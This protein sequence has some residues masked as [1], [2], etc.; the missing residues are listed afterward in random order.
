MNSLVSVV[1]PVYNTDQFY[2]K[3]CI[4]SLREQTLKNIEIILV[5]DGSVC[6][7]A[8]VCDK[9]AEYDSRIISLHQ[10]NNGVSAARNLGIQKASGKYITFV[11][12]DDW[13]DRSVLQDV[14]DVA[15]KENAD[16]TL[17]GGTINRIGRN[18]VETACEIHLEPEDLRNKDYLYSACCFPKNHKDDFV[19]ATCSKLYKREFLLKNEISFSLGVVFGED[20]IFA[21]KAFSC[22]SSVAY[23]DNCGYHYR[24]NNQNQATSR[25]LPKLTE[26]MERFVSLMDLSI[27][28][29]CLNEKY[30]TLLNTSLI[31]ILFETILP[32]VFFHPNNPLKSKEKFSSFV[33]YMRS[34]FVK[35]LVD[36]RINATYLKWSHRIALLFCQK[37]FYSPFLL[38]E[39][40]W[41]LQR[42]L[43]CWK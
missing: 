1:V 13:C 35:S 34:P 9:Y 43:D 18:G 21:V 2:L 33:S 27:R 16:V 36:A 11:D 22:C 37:D 12:S 23:S 32:Q 42:S 39:K 28:E 7:C 24:I 14:Y 26:S 20:R 15:E 25:Y 17:F 4:A 41:N 6:A 30:K 5:D 10:E 19:L 40:K 38:V 3:K 8:A 29:K 31:V